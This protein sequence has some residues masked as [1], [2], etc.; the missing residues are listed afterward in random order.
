MLREIKIKD[1]N[2][3]IGSS[4]KKI[5]IE[6]TLENQL[7]D[8]EIMWLM[9][10]SNKKIVF[11]KEIL[12]NE[13]R[14]YLK[15]VIR[16]FRDRVDYIEKSRNSFADDECY[17]EISVDDGE[18]STFLPNFNMNDMYLGMEFNREY[19]LEELGL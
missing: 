7:S 2:S 13:E 1:I 10:S 18:D 9:A 19:S 5:R 14:K 6:A 15:E 3:L 4:D 12:D 16:P 8:E 11:Q 17:I